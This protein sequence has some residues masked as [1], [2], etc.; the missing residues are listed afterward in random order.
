[1]AIEKLAETLL[2]KLRFITK[3]ET[4]IGNPIQAGEATIIPVSRVSV[5]FG[6]GGHQ[7]KGDT[8][9]SGGGASV[10]P[11][12][13]L[14][15]NGEDVRIMPITKDSSLASK[16]MDIIPDVVNKFSKKKED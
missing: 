8:S 12:A 5:G 14:V 16:V 13:F 6:F 4:V 15:I 2:E 10:E 3:A 7:N 11:V 9:A 1:M